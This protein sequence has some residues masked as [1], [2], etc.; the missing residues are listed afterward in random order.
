[1]LTVMTDELPLKDAALEVALTVRVPKDTLDRIDAL[2]RA[3]P[4]RIPR[5]SWL[6]EAIYEKLFKEDHVEGVLDIFWENSA[7]A[8]AMSYRPRFLL[9]FLILRHRKGGPVA[10]MTVV[11]DDSLER[12]LV[13]W[14]F[15]SE[16]AKGWIQKIKADKSVSIPNV[17]MPAERVGPY[18][19][20]VSGMGIQR[21][22]RDGR[23]AILSPNHWRNADDNAVKGDKI[24]ILTS[25]G[26]S[27]RE[28][29]ITPSGKVLVTVEKHFV[30]PGWQTTVAFKEAS[31]EEA[32]EFLDIYRQYTLD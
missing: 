9:H 15:T 4:T 16:N 6:L 30:S 28:A 10:P 12:H 8:G 24:V 26:Y 23:M 13:E 5:H 7:E 19:F 31:K 11:G 27:D 17:M 1:M 21:R 22:L 25:T 20:R 32:E 2:V 3:R 29:T 18:G 14:G